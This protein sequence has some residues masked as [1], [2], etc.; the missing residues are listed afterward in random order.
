MQDSSRSPVLDNSHGPGTAAAG[1]SQGSGRPGCAHHAMQ[2]LQ[3]Q[4]QQHHGSLRPAAGVRV[5]LPVW[6]LQDGPLLQQGLSEGCLEAAQAYS[7]C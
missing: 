7:S 1:N 5:Q 4:L 2:R 3:P 6:W